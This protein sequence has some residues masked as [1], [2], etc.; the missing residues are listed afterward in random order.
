MSV[1]RKRRLPRVDRPSLAL[2]LDISWL[3]TSVLI[4]WWLGTAALPDSLPHLATTLH[5]LLAVA[6]A[7]ALL[8]AVVLHEVAH[9]LVSLR[10][11]L[12]VASVRLY[13]FGGVPQRDA[14]AGGP[15]AEFITATVGPATSLVTAFLLLVAAESTPDGSVLGVLLGYLAAINA[16]LGVLNLVPAF[17][18]DGGRALR[19]V[20]WMLRGEFSWATTV[21]A[22]LASGLGLAL[23]AMGIFLI[24]SDGTPVG[25]LTALLLGFTLR[26]AATTSYRHL[27]TRRSLGSIPVRQLMDENPITVQRALSVSSL[28]EDFIHKHQLKMLPVVD[29]ERLL[30]YVTAQRVKQVPREEWARQSIGT[31]AMP[32]SSNDTVGPDTAASE[33]LDRM[34]HTGLT[35]LMVVDND[36]L[37]GTITLQDLLRSLQ[38]AGPTETNGS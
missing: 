18:L 33:A 23:A 10:Y 28:V 12:G 2:R 27:L 14:G 31:I 17:P 16:M 22:R 30:G 24:L 32:F 19:A 20:L 36:R 11:G 38:A 34:T 6:L 21:S 13:P 25:G 1:F 37:A 29:G 3:P 5:W 4:I 7:L 8:L 26:S 15:E 35:R 9:A